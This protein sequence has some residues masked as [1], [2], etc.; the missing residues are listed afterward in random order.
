MKV[1]NMDFFD[2]L[3][4]SR[5]ELL[6]L[7]TQLY[8]YGKGGSWDQNPGRV[9]LILDVTG[10]GFPV[11]LCASTASVGADAAV[12]LLLDGSPKWIHIS[13]TDVEFINYDSFS[14]FSEPDPAHD[15][16]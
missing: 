6:R 8:W 4:K 16:C 12:R 1:V 9:C 13:M 7:K 11:E 3:Q 15:I 2:K 5:G 14:N 10:C